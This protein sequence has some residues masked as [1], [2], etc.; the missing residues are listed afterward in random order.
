M[1]VLLV[2]SFAPPPHPK[3]FQINRFGIIPK[4]IPGKWRLITDWSFPPEQSVNN[5]ISADV[6]RFRCKRIHSAV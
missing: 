4:S 2:P 5:G 6:C 1:S 3:D